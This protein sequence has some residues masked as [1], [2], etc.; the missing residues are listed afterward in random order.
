MERRIVAIACLESQ[1]DWVDRLVEQVD[2]GPDERWLLEREVQRRSGGR[3]IALLAIGGPGGD[4]ERLFARFKQ[5]I[6]RLRPSGS[7]LTIRSDRVI[8]ELPAPGARPAPAPP[9]S[10]PVPEPE[11]AAVPV[12]PTEDEEVEAVAAPEFEE[13]IPFDEDDW[14]DG[15]AASFED[16]PASH[17]AEEIQ[18]DW[19]AQL[20]EELEEELID[21]TEAPAMSDE[22]PAA[23]SLPPAPTIESLPEASPASAELES[24]APSSDQLVYRVWFGTNRRRDYSAGGD[25]PRFGSRRGREVGYGVVDV[26]IPKPEHRRVGSVGTPFWKRLLRLQLADDHIRIRD[27]QTLDS[28]RFFS[29]LADSVRRSRET[30]DDCVDALCFIHGFNVHFDDA[31]VRAAQLGYDLGV[32]GATAFFSWPSAGEV[33]GYVSDSAAIEASERAIT[34]FLVDFSEK[35]GADRVHLIAHSMGNRGVLRA[36]QRIGS[37][38][39]AA[40]RV[41][42]DQVVLAAPDIDRDLFLDLASVYGQFARRTTLYSSD[43]DLA[44]RASGTVNAG[45]RAGYYPPYTVIDG[46]DTIAVPDL[47]IDFLGH[48]NFAKARELLTDIHVLLRYNTPPNRRQHISEDVSD[49][50]RFWRLRK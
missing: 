6:D 36:L 40:G 49:G 11:P 18:D 16:F 9:A 24:P 19:I 37:N 32:A 35:S 47:A 43:A 30:L 33:T 34:E 15:E 22:A 8:V 31:A 3:V 28:E 7:R 17:A 21:E 38:A 48:S 12:A 14:E 27:V 20:H 29:G 39:E 42:F 41:R 50:L 25:R 23:A 5:Q 45:P 4:V 2:I 13:A 44:L 26:T 46:V 10:E 1:L